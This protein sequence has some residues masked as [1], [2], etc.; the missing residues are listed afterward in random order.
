MLIETR[1]NFSMMKK[2]EL[3]E[4]LCKYDIINQ[5]ILQKMKRKQ[6]YTM[7]KI[8]TSKQFDEYSEHAQRCI[9]Y[10]V[11]HGHNKK[12]ILELT[13]EEIGK[14]L[15]EED[16]AKESMSALDDIENKDNTDNNIEVIKCDKSSIYYMKQNGEEDIKP[17]DSEWTKFVLSHFSEDEKEGENP[18]VEG[19]RRVSELLIGEIIEEGCDLISP[20]TFDNGMRA[21]VKAWVVFLVR[22]KN[23]KIYTEHTKKVEALADCCPDNSFDDD[24]LKISFSKFP[25]A[26]AETR[27]KGRVF[28]SALKLKR[29]VC[30]EET[31]KISKIQNEGTD[32]ESIQVGAMTNIRL[33]TDRYNVSIPKLL[34]YLEL[35]EGDSPSDLKQLKQTE[36]L[37]VQ[38]HLSSL[39]NG[40]VPDQIK[41]NIQ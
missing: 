11:S 18:R 37:I 14:F 6:L 9:P 34:K 33:L 15:I 35:Q 10:L 8:V 36:A 13:S 40:N 27:A 31:N 29:I 19:L 12:T 30:A 26:L 17:C 5:D 1:K 2:K 39:G 38:K 41:R 7:V 23:G 3:I 20:P 32:E 28:R 21:C 4:Y 24:S 25:T 22:N 16:S